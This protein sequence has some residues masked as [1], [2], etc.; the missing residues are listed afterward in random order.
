MIKKSKNLYYFFQFF[1]LKVIFNV[2][3]QLFFYTYIFFSIIAM[4]QKL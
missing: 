4:A 3:Y 1:N 2:Y